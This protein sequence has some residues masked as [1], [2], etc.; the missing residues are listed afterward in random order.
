MTHHGVAAVAN[1]VIA[2]GDF[3]VFADHLGDEFVEG[4]PGRPA[5]FFTCLGGV[6]EEGFD[7]GGAEVAGVYG[8][9]SSSS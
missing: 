5:E 3:E 2:L 4:D 7:F 1:E 6:A 8:D 9:G